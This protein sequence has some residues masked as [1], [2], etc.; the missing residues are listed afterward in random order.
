MSTVL[1]L[2]WEYPP[3]AMGNLSNRLKALLPV[4]NSL[5]PLT[6]VVRAERDEVVEMDGMRVRK[7]GTSIRTSPN[8]IAYSH[9]LN[10]DLTRG[11]SEAVH[12]D[13]EI[14]LIHTHDWVSSIA[15]I[16]LASLF[17][18]PLITSVYSTEVIRARPPLSI[19]GRG[20]YDLERHCFQR[21]NALAVGDGVMMSHLTE[22]YRLD[23]ARVEV[24]PTPDLVN[25]LYGRLLG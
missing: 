10:I 9:A 2:S 20:I 25:A 12:T 4:L 1:H 17:G 19:V 22:H 16:Y 3:W 23:P 21:A 11:G 8:F 5:T 14:K 18:L 24:C 13:P 6:L 7:V 15:G